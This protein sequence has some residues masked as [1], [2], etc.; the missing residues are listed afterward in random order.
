[1]SLMS[2]KNNLTIDSTDNFQFEDLFN[3]EDIQNL[4]D[5]FADTHGVASIITHPDG[6]PITKPSNFCRLCRIIRQT[7]KGS[8]NCFYTDAIVG[9]QDTSGTVVQSCL[10]GGLWDAGASITVNGRHIANWVIGQ[11]RNKNVDEHTLINY[12][13]EIGANKDDFIAALNEAP[14]MS[15]DQF[16][17]VAKMLFAFAKELSDKAYQNI[18]LKI[19]IAE[20]DKATSLLRESE[21]RFHLLFNKAPLGYQSLDIQGNFIEVNQ[22]WLD[23]LGY[24]RD[25]VI[26]KWFGDFLSPAYQ[27]G[28]RKRFP[29]F[30]AQ[31][32]IHSEFEMVHKDGRQLFIAFEGRIGYDNDGKFKQT[33]CILQDITERKRV[34]KALLEAEWKFLALFEKGPI[35]VAYHEMIYDESGNPVDYRFID[36]NESYIQLTGVDPRGKT[37]KQ[38]FPGIEAEPFDWIGTYAKVARTGKSIR[39][40]QHFQVNDRWYDCAAFQYKPDHFVTAFLEITDRKRAEKELLK[41]EERYHLLLESSGIGVGMYSLDGIILFFNA[42][43]I[44]H[45]G[46]KVEDYV[47]KSLAEVF[48]EEAAAIYN[49]R[50]Q[51]AANSDKSLEY[52]DF[53]TY[54]GRRFCFLSNHTRIKN[55]DGKII[56]IQVLAHDITDR[57]WVEEAFR[58][59]RTLLRTLIDNIPDSI[60][61]K[62][63]FGRKTLANLTELHY[64]GAKAESEILGKSDFDLY[65]K[66][67]AEKFFADDQIVMQTGK[68]ILNREEYIIDQN[69][70]KRFLLSSKIPL[71][72]NQGQIIGLVGIGRDIT[73]RVQAEEQLILLSRAVEQSPV[74]VVITGKEG[75]IEYVNPKFTE[76]TGYTADEVK[77]KNPR[78]L[79]SGLHPK[80]FYK[81]LWNTILSGN[82]WKGEFQNKKKNGDFYWESAVISPILNNQGEISFFV[83]IKEDITEKKKMVEDLI[84]AKEQAEES[85][86]LKSSF[87][88][89]MSHEIRT[90]MNGILGFTNLLKEPKLSGEEQQEYIEII[91]K[92]GIRMLNI[93][94]DIISISKVESGQMDVTLSDTNINVQIEYIYT[95]F[96]PETEQKGIKLIHNCHLPN[97][98]AIIKT[99]REKLY[100]ILTNLV[101]NAIK[102]TNQGSIE[103]GYILKPEGGGQAYGKDM[104]DKACLVSTTTPAELEFFVKDTG[105]G[106]RDEQQGFIFERFRQGSES[107]TR[108][109]EGAGLG[110]AISKA[111]VEMLGGTIW[112]ESKHGEGSTFYFTL[113][114]NGKQDIANTKNNITT[115]NK[116]N[117]Q[118]SPEIRGLKI[119][120]AEDDEGSEKFISLA[121]RRFSKEIL[122]ARTGLEAVETCR[123]HPDIDL[124]LMD[125]KMP[126]MDGYEA[127]RQI[128]Q[129]NKKIIIIAQTA[130]ALVGDQ[131]KVIDAGCND[132]IPKPIQRERL[133][134]LL[135]KYFKKPD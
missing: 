94:N 106:I 127:T 125:I 51:E 90:P 129:F 100:A 110:L 119:L 23:T 97:E 128:R 17:K 133:I 39:F 59:E 36:A 60:Y 56:G 130:Y 93:I 86:R 113:P 112:L 62:D 7:A 101:K 3:I 135:L 61:S 35:G 122:K 109:Y 103:F 76:I 68:T 77:G 42:K 116:T 53:V 47:G 57:K 118:N 4:Q 115:S 64:L 38:A 82:N 73:E 89:N 84:R 32:Q 114:Y 15:A 131:E 78:I 12:A 41:S 105:L 95:F 29:I 50:I 66:E 71:R 9:S 13:E 80:L 121:I 67:L 21:E 111:Y 102:F 96:K 120:I 132:Y 1:M 54:G 65:P 72:D 81:N 92:S 123:N 55:P 34:E 74:T 58:N 24:T 43:A 10:S 91:E 69:G 88:A 25:E 19:Q 126:E 98:E 22:Q 44:Q 33:H 5:L 134:A 85:D 108:N 70:N 18:Q 46:G 52:E 14:A 79:Q 104:G 45:L 63:L 11:V 40:E 27:D 2:D 28:F 37:V 99:D 117:Y 16:N 48:G 87:L 124:V 83:A 30:K 31:G 75:R 107:L 6:T 26:G 49:S 8:A 20:R